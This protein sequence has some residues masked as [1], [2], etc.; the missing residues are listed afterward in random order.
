VLSK[1]RQI[2]ASDLRLVQLVDNLRAREMPCL[3]LQTE[4]RNESKLLRAL[5]AFAE[6]SPC[7]LRGDSSV[8]VGAALILVQ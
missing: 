3:I 8:H 6:S 2:G 4:A 1:P 5:G 7:A